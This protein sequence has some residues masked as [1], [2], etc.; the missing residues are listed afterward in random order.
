MAYENLGLHESRKQLELLIAAQ[1]NGEKYKITPLQE[2]DTIDC[3]AMNVLKNYFDALKIC[4]A[5]DKGSPELGLLEKTL[6]NCG[7]YVQRYTER[8]SRHPADESDV[9]NAMDEILKPLFDDYVPKSNFTK[10]VKGY[11]PDGSI[12]SLGALI[13]YKFLDSKKDLKKAVDEVFADSVGYFTDD[14]WKYF[15]VVLYATQHF[16]QPSAIEH[17]IRSSC[18]HLENLEVIVITGKGRRI[19]KEKPAPVCGEPPALL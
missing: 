3:D 13:E 10:R 19:K 6:R 15:F 2:F 9:Q 16:D 4:F 12:Q 8:E 5:E 18:A 14:K 11:Q 17:Q 1:K 7:Y